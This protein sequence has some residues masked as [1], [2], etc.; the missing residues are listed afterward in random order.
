[1][2]FVRTADELERIE[3]LFSSPRF[4]G[5]ERLSVEFLSDRESVARLLPPPLKPADRPLVVAGVGR[6]QGDATGDYSGGSVYL[7][8]EHEGLQGLYALSMWMDT[9][10]AVVFGRDVFGEPKKLATTRLFRGETNFRAMVI[11][12][13]TVILELRAE[14]GPDQGPTTSQGVAFNFRSRP[15]ANGVGLED[16]VVLT[17][18]H[19]ESEVRSERIGSGTVVLRGTRHDPLDE[20]PVASVLRATFSEHDLRAR[21]EPVARVSAEQFLPFHYGRG[22]D[23]LAFD[24][25]APPS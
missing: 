16:P 2:G 8:A 5:G 24:E 10:A 14:L 17:A 1:M 15:A 6:W 18:A 7:A 21:C 23:W 12:T 3:A 22:D 13:G 25:T 11:R 20:L 19:F 9:E 4:L